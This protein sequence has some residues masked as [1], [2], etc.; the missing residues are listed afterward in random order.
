MI[1]GHP[2]SEK[3]ET[4]VTEQQMIEYL[5]Q[6]P[7]FFVRHA[8]LLSQVRLSNPHGPRA[9][10]LQE[11]QADM[12]RDRIRSLEQRMME[13]IRHGAENESIGLKLHRWTESLMR[14]R[15]A[16]ELPGTMV[17]QLQKQFHIPQAAVRVWNA[18]PAYIF[19]DFAQGVSE[20]IKLFAESLPQPYC[21]LNLGVE[22]IKWLPKPEEVQSMAIVPLRASQDGKVFGLLL[23]GSP[24][25]T[26]YA[27]DM[28]IDFLV[29]I[30]ELAGAGLSRL[31]A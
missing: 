1:P 27:P 26:R 29:R 11:R 4:P 10:S 12:L 23:L 7:E 8:E 13:M 19:C 22:V 21:G 15:E 6:T 3:Q 18:D 14:T 31:Q 24:D 20:D 16:A 2:G 17:E 30:G 25:P 28:G 9:I 5:Q